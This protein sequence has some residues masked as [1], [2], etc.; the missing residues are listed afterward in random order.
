MRWAGCSWRGGLVLGGQR[1]RA[2]WLDYDESI[3]S[4][5]FYLYEDLF[6]GL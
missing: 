5:S 3:F 6:D 1:W 4:S 2:K